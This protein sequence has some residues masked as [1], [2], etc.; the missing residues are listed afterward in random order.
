[1]SYRYDF[2]DYDNST[3]ALVQR[4]ETGSH[5]AA[6]YLDLSHYRPI[7]KGASTPGPCGLQSRTDGPA[8]T[9]TPSEADLERW[10]GEGRP[11]VEGRLR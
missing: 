2:N 4:S 10:S 9:G 6:G 3:V 5:N 11:W 7:G 1:M 8:A